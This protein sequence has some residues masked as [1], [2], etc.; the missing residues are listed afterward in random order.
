MYSMEFRQF[1]KVLA[2]C[3]VTLLM[4]ASV[5]VKSANA[6]VLGDIVTQAGKTFLSSVFDNYNKNSKTVFE[7]GYG[8]ADKLIKELSAQLERASDSKLKPQERKRILQSIAKSQDNI[9]K[10][11]NSFSELANKTDK[12]G[13]EFK[14]SLEKLVSSATKEFNSKLSTDKD[15]YN[16]IANALASIAKDTKSVDVNNVAGFFDSIKGN[17]DNFNKI[18]STAAGLYKAFAS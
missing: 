17:I 1:K 5:T 13:D 16:G 9:V 14:G 2:V 6:D 10:Y 7:E 11:A 12:Y 15:A 18:S 3:T 4:F 8:N